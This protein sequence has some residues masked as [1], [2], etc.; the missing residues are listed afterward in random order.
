MTLSEQMAQDAADAKAPLSAQMQA[1]AGAPA[2]PASPAAQPQSKLLSFGAGAGKAMGTG[3]LALQQIVGKGLTTAGDATGID[4][5]QQGGQWLSN[6]AS[7]G[8][9]KL[10][11]ENAPYQAANPKTN[12]AGNIAGAILSPVNKLVPMGGPAANLVTAVGKG[13]MQGAALGALTSPV[14]G[15]PSPADFASEKL[16]QAVWG[17]AGGGA[18]GAAGYGLAQGLSKAATALRSTLNKATATADPAA[19]NAKVGE[20]L[21]QQGI[22]PAVLRPGI[23]DSLRDQVLA[24]AKSGNQVDPR[25][26]RNLADSQTLPVPVPM[27]QGQ[28]SRDPMQFAKEQNLRGITGVGEP[29]TDLYQQQNRALIENLNAMGAK[30]APAMIDASQQ[31]LNALQT[32]SNKL[33]AGVDQAYAG[34]RNMDGQSARMDG[35]AFTKN[36]NAALDAG[37]ALG[38][39]V[40]S[41]IANVMNDIATGK[42]PLSVEIAQRLDQIWGKEANAAGGG[43]QIAINTIRD[44]LRSATVSDSLGP[45]AMQAYQQAKALAA[46]RF[47]MIDANPALKAIENGNVAPDKFVQN[48]ILRGNAGDVKNLVGMMNQADPSATPAIKQSIVDWMKR[49]AIN[50]ASEENGIFSQSAFNKIVGDPQMQARLSQVFSPAEMGQFQQLGRVAENAI[51]VPKAAAVNTSNTTSAAANLV[52][53]EVNSGTISG[54]LSLGARIPALSSASQVGQQALQGKRLAELVSKTVQPNVQ[55]GMG[56]ADSAAA[57]Q[58]L[59]DLMR[60]TGTRAGSAVAER[61]AQ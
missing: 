1:D 49:Q 40:P 27:T 38:G 11:A 43:A 52:K 9:A 14:E 8:L 7:A 2:S 50:G 25:A 30:G 47:A 13:A 46:Q 36:A 16:K 42:L 35:A 60:Q 32:F 20:V 61:A 15:D 44:N 57:I 26:L 34:V 58:R 5:V 28:L 10:N 41:S 21:S 59:S 22:D 29:I 51:A 53:A 55:S 31:G 33:K 23:F 56:S 45:E 18:G 24:A 17:A 3:V 12:I 39:F 37:G 4:S 48:F 6:D 19:A 54:L